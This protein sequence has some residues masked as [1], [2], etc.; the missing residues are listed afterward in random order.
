MWFR[1][2]SPLM[3]ITSNTFY[4]CAATLRMHC[5]PDYLCLFVCVCVCVGTA[6]I[7]FRHRF[8]ISRAHTPSDRDTLCSAP[9]YERSARRRGQYLHNTQQ[10]QETNIMPSRDWNSLS[11]LGFELPQTNALNRTATEITCTP[12]TYC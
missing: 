3:D 10:S 8:K 7:G 12:L 2:V 11:L 4:K 5:K 1:P 6:H 9:L